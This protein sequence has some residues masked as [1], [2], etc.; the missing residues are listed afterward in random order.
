MVSGSIRQE[1]LTFVVGVQGRTS[2]PFAA[3]VHGQVRGTCYLHDARSRC[4]QL[5]SKL[6]STVNQNI[7]KSSYS[8]LRISCVPLTITGHL[9][10][11]AWLF[12][13]CETPL[14]TSSLHPQNDCNRGGGVATLALFPLSSSPLHPEKVTQSNFQA[15]IFA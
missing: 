1:R 12:T 10:G 14:Y 9:S 13:Q 2:P 6:R 3:T 11:T 4:T 5:C 7:N 8:S 15:A